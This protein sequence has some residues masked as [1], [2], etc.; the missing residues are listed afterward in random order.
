ME[1]PLNENGT[2]R[3]LKMF[4]RS[5]TAKALMLVVLVLVMMA[6]LAM[7]RG[8][9][10]EREMTAR[11]ARAEIMK[12]WGSELTLA[13]PL[14]AVP[15]TRLST[16]TDKNATT[17]TRQP[18]PFTMMVAPSMLY[19]ETTL[20]TQV[21]SRGI[22]S[23]PL[24][25]GEI[26]L[27]GGFDIPRSLFPSGDL[28]EPALNE[29]AP[30][31]LHISLSSQKGIVEINGSAGLPSL[32]FEPGSCFALTGVDGEEGAG[33]NARF[34]WPEWKDDIVQVPF[35][36]T[37]VVHGGNGARF[38]PVAQTTRMKMES[39][40]TSPSFQ[41]AFLPETQ[42]VSSKGFNAEW[43]VNYL[44]RDIP[45]VW[46]LGRTRIRPQA[47]LFGVDFF[48]AVDTYS[49]NTRAVKYAVLFLLVPFLT[50]FLLE[51]WARRRVHPVSYLLVGIGNVVFYL[52]LLSLSEQMAF[53]LAYV[54]AGVAVTAML[55][56]Y[57]RSLL[58]AWS[59]SWSMGV[60]AL[61]SYVLLYA[62]LNAASYALLI[63]SVCAFAV[64]AFVMYA[65]R[66]FD[67]DGQD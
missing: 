25:S 49:L 60:A 40:W 38:L 53:W 65:T 30:L 63:G 42:T 12:A 15:C 10:G 52:L 17:Q 11:A 32:S 13:G 18:V 3:R 37:L 45:L 61:L 44:S 28:S 41:G 47:S 54:V 23:V 67:W 4:S 59:R 14:L 55:T 33:V 46:E 62:V 1:E 57:A 35:S 7:L 27:R 56:L 31:A 66:Q 64:T 51:V 6:P 21:H 5:Y 39:D 9:V 20:S 36:I 24:Y 26:S 34:G 22:F 2:A 29:A 19:I 16:P 43:T 48:T 58:G 50:L 8:L